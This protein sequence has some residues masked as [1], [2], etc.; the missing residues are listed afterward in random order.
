ML[1]LCNDPSK[2]YK[3]KISIEITHRLWPHNIQGNSCSLTI[4]KWTFLD[5]ERTEDSCLSWCEKKIIELLSVCYRYHDISVFHRKALSFSYVCNLSEL[6]TFLHSEA[7]EPE[8]WLFPYRNF[9]LLTMH[10]KRTKLLWII[11]FIIFTI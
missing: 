10:L 6:M 9:F 5:G 11:Y 7:I 4:Q 2:G 1:K 3:A 8:T